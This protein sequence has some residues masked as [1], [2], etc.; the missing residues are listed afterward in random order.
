MENQIVNSIGNTIIDD[1]SDLLVDIG[2]LGIDFVFDDSPLK[3]IPVVKTIYSIAKTGIAI[4]DRHLLNKTLIFINKLNSNNLSSEEYNEYKSKLKEK[5]K[6]IYKELE[7]I[8]IIL[9]KLVE[10]EKAVILAN[11]YTAYINKK[12]NFSEFKNFTLILDNFLLFDEYNLGMLF[13]HDC[14]LKDMQ[15]SYGTASRLISLGLAYNMSGFVRNPISNNISFNPPKNDVAITDFG[16]KFY[17]YGIL[18]DELE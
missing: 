16:R 8:V 1:N 9:D 6:N 17:Q 11:L 10:K 12:I 13:K 14:Q 4:R 5:D 2:E 15:D 3:E 18:N 7:H